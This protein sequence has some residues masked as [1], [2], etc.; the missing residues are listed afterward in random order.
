[1]RKKKSKRNKDKIQIRKKS[2][3]EKGK[4]QMRK[5]KSK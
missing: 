4:V 5:T 1:M 2:P 3:N